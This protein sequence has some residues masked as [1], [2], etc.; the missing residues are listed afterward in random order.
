MRDFSEMISLAKARGPRKVVLVGSDD[1]EAIRALKLASDEGIAKP[2]L[3]G[4]KEKT[5]AIL[6]EEDSM[7]K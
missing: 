3:V 2:F 6:S 4:E 7:V 1:R 5:R